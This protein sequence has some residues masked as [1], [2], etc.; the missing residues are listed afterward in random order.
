MNIARK[1][2]VAVWTLAL[3][4]ALAFAEAEMRGT[5]VKVDKSEKRLVVQTDKG[6]ETLLLVG[7]TKGLDN[8]KEGAMVAV[9]YTEK[10]GLPKVIAITAQQTGTVRI[11]PR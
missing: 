2:A 3:F 9:K 11:V 10:D 8:A 1:T 7:S 4:P 5:V 6:E